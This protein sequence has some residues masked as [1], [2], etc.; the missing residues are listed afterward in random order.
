MMQLLKVSKAFIQAIMTH[1]AGVYFRFPKHEAARSIA[2]PPW[3]G[4]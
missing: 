4:C 2:T 1:G 3:I